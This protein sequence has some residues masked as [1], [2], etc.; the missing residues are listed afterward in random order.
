[1]TLTENTAS[2]SLVHL[3]RFEQRTRELF[4]F[5]KD[6]VSRQVPAFGR[7][8]QEELDE[9]LAHLFGEDEAAMTLALKGYV[10]FS[11]DA[12][13]L[14]KRFE[15]ERKYVA[16]TYAEAA[17]RVYHNEEYMRGLYLPG[18][19]LSHYLWPHHYRQL[20]HFRQVFLPEF[21]KSEGATFYDVGIGTGFYSRQ[22][23]RASAQAH[24]TG[25]DISAH[26][27][28]YATAQLE[29]FGVADRYSIQ[30]R[31]VVADP[32]GE[33]TRFLVSV[34]V[35]E[36]LEDPLSFLKALRGMLVPGGFGFITAAITA[37]NDDHIYLYETARDVVVQL[38]EA[39]FDV[40]DVYE[41]LA[42]PPKADEP[43]PRLGAF[44]V[45]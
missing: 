11:L 17:A 5:M 39:G 35:L 6:I 29:A 40:A 3:D 10:R 16:R 30:C 31:D 8:W 14:Q 44:L 28:A 36:H 37:P 33:P 45:R 32:V 9:T 34:E 43:V 13:K 15:K 25:F 12:V 20:Q 19:L 2:Q 4:P 18:I 27:I 38:E 1:M 22:L 23:L 41:D 24:G 7:P 42:Y 21:L 26:S